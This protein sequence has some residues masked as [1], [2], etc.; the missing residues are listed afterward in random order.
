MDQGQG[1]RPTAECPGADCDLVLDAKLPVGRLPRVLHYPMSS[2]D[3]P[4]VQT[5]S[6]LCCE[7]PILGSPAGIQ[8]GVGNS[9]WWSLLR[10]VGHQ[11]P[12]SHIH[13]SNLHWRYCQ[14]LRRPR[15]RHPTKSSRLD[16]ARTRMGPV[17]PP[18]ELVQALCHE[19]MRDS[20]PV[21]PC[22]LT[23]V[24]ETVSDPCGRI[25]KLRLRRWKRVARKPR[26]PKW[27]TE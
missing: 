22:L 6:F 23:R 18:F 14:N 5:W 9:H 26:R 24:Q 17:Q 8:N 16:R 10:V 25:Y 19:T 4:E 21:D 27:A 13:R 1:V 20:Q 11:S 3:S 15:H 12:G 2:R 7:F